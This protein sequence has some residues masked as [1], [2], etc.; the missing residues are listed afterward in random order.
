M[1]AGEG[2][3]VLGVLPRVS[4]R[5]VVRLVP[6]QARQ[7]HSFPSRARVVPKREKNALA[8]L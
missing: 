3:R 4:M 7:A 1:G 6:L 5:R 8:Q 2:G